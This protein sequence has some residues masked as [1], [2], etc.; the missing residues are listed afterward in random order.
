MHKAM[1]ELKYFF[2]RLTITVMNKTKCFMIKSYRM[3]GQKT[4]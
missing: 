1:V 2:I 3:K 4:A